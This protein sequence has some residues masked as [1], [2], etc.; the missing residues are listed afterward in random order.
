MTVDK[1]INVTN[2]NDYRFLK[3]MFTYIWEKCSVK[4]RVFNLDLNE[5]YYYENKRR[6]RKKGTNFSQTYVFL[7]TS[8]VKIKS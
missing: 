8:W 2:L 5:K 1:K 6:I 4:T 3:K 7:T